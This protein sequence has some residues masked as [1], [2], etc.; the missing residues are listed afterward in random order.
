MKKLLIVPLM[1]VCGASAFSQAGGEIELPDVTTVI[2]SGALTAGKD[3][4]PGYSKIIPKYDEERIELPKIE[5]TTDASAAEIRSKSETP[6]R[7]VYAEGKIG[8]GFPFNFSSAFSIF[9][10]AG[11]SPFSID[12]SHDAADGFSGGSVEDGYFARKTA[13][14]AKKEFNGKRGGIKLS[15]EYSSDNNGF[16]SKSNNLTDETKHFAKGAFSGEKSFSNGLFVFSDF[17][18]DYYRRYGTH[19][20][21][22]ENQSFENSA[23]TLNLIPRAGFGWKNGIVSVSLDAEYDASLNLKGAE[24]LLTAENSASTKSAHR[25]EFSLDFEFAGKNW[26]AFAAAGVVFGSAIGG[27]SVVVPWTAGFSVEFPEGRIVRSSNLTIEGGCASEPNFISEVETALPW[28]CSPYLPSETSDWY[29]KACAELFLLKDIGVYF[30]AEFY[31]TAFKNGV[32]T[33]V[34]S[35]ENFSNSGYYYA[36]AKDRTEFNT[37]LAAEFATGPVHYEL[38]WNAFWIDVPAAEEKFSV[39]GNI[40]VAGKSSKWNANIFL[41]ENFGGNADIVPQ[42]GAGGAMK[43]SDSIRLE[44]A[45]N[46]IVKL[47]T[48]SS[49]KFADSK[50]IK[51]SGNVTFYV[52]FQF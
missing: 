47:V 26:S 48:N 32:W 13:V 24:T 40:S 30:D 1:F 22:I 42:I 9:K 19:F 16:Q 41:K 15:A 45:V 25:G 51:K 12:F 11:T 27:N 7:S 18:A 14:G 8:A 20:G 34:Y 28:S 50:Y 46:D 37:N 17:S 4:V 33:C 52:R 38:K 31:K 44:L 21:G 29:A 36:S 43:A 6:A 5:N 3:S 39:E 23:E 2:S 10:T 49:R 35:G